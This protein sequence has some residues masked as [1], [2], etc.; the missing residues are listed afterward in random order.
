MPW[1]EHG[2]K[3]D[4]VERTKAGHATVTDYSKDSAAA[5]IVQGLLLLMMKMM[6]MMTMMMTMTMTDDR[7][8]P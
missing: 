1:T 2:G 5:N 8:Q 6:M 7:I 4:A 3:T